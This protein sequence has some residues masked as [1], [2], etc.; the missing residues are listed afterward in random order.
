MSRSLRT[1]IVNCHYVEGESHMMD[2]LIMAMSINGGL[3]VGII[4]YT[5]YKTSGP[6]VE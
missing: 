6:D 3:Y 5:A 1:N 4:A 2:I